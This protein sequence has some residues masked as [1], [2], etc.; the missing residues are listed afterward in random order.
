MECREDNE[1]LAY[2]RKARHVSAYWKVLGVFLRVRKSRLDA[3]QLENHKM[4]SCMLEMLH[5]WMK[6]DG[7]HSKEKLE[8]ALKELYSNPEKY[9]KPITP[10]NQ[11]LNCMYMFWKR[12]EFMHL[13]A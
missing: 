12:Q 13:A 6:Q 3:I 2:L 1:L 11:F 4:D 9:S 5:S 10:R 7:H 8:D